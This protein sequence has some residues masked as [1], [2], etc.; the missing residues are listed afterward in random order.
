MGPRHY[1]RGNIN[2]WVKFF[3]KVKGFNGATTLQSW[4]REQAVNCWLA[5]A[6]FNGATT[7]QSWKLRETLFP[8]NVPFVVSMGPRHYSR[9]NLQYECSR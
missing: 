2:R 6:G 8:S 7:L 9:G 3:I 5:V 1:S 4:K